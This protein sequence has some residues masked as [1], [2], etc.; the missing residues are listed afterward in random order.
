MQHDA[1]P[2]GLPPAKTVWDL[3]AD[4]A[5]FPTGLAPV[6]T[7]PAPPIGIVSPAV[8]PLA[9]LRSALSHVVAL[10]P[11]H[12]VYNEPLKAHPIAPSYPSPFRSSGR[13]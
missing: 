7:E 12:C 13:R 6:G 8:D 10:C 4:A 5:A 1:L 9:A 3:G 11:R 2:D